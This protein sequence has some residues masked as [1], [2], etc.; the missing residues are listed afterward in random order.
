MLNFLATDVIVAQATPSGLGAVGIVRLSGPGA[1]SIATAL[2]GEQDQL[3]WLRQ[4]ARTL[5]LYLLCDPESAEPL[6]EGLLVA[7]D[8]PASFTGED[9]VEFQGHGAPVVMDSVVQACLKAGA[10]LAER[11]EF[12]YRAFRSGK[13]DLSEAEGLL[14][15]AS[16]SGRHI[17]EGGLQLLQGSMRREIE[18]LKSQLTTCLAEL[19]VAFDYPEDHSSGF[20][21]A[22]IAD[23]LGSFGDRL[24][25]LLRSYERQQT[26]TEGLKV[27]LIGAPN[28]GKS[29]LL[30]ALVGINRALVHATPGTTRDVVE[31]SLIQGGQRF[32]LADTAGIRAEAV[33]V[34]AAGIA[35]ATGYIEGADLII[36]VIDASD[37]PTDVDADLVSIQPETPRLTVLNKIDLGQH[38]CIEGWLTFAGIRQAWP[39]SALTGEGIEAVR[40][41]MQSI[42]EYFASRDPGINHYLTQRQYE[43]LRAALN[44]VDQ[45]ILAVAQG[46]PED[47]IAI[48]LREVLTQL[49][50]ITGEVYDEAILQAIFSQFC[51]GK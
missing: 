34:E 28:A 3:R 45:A 23:L 27:V 17:Q 6:D 38:D 5:A 31:A 42:G 51:V 24:H 22:E 12:S 43:C 44:E 2:L 14:T 40:N 33:D 29:S 10:R 19:E 25:G 20:H 30:N 16:A 39:V 1:R 8:S 48:H 47:L 9:V 11:G 49:L 35:L 4:R 41:T 7:F 36:H 50:T 15:L 13:M 46:L 32:V 21:Q 26:Q 18:S 37:I